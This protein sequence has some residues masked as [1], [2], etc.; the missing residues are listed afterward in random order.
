MN[1]APA[2]LLHLLVNAAL[3]P[4]CSAAHSRQDQKNAGMK[5]GVGIILQKDPLFFEEYAALPGSFGLMNALK[6]VG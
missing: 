3:Q 1:W 4:I 5:A 6:K 2:E